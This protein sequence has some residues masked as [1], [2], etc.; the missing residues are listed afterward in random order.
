MI[1]QQERVLQ[2]AGEQAAGLLDALA[3]ALE[4]PEA[5]VLQGGEH[6]VVGGEE[7][8]EGHGEDVDDGGAVLAHPV[9]AGHGVE[10]GGGV[11]EVGHGL[12]GE[13]AA[14][15]YDVVEGDRHAAAGEGVAHVHGVAED[16]H[17]GCF[18]GHGGQEAVGH[19]SQFA[20]FDG[21]PE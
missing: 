3:A 7:G 13:E 2:Q 11:F 19:A 18:L 21:L 14:D 1:H 5:P 4:V 17:A 8:V 12:G 9:E 15:V 20:C 6:G 16:D 10:D